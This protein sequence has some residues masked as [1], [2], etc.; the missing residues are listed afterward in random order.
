MSGK[1]TGAQVL[2]L[3]SSLTGVESQIALLDSI[4]TQLGGVSYFVLSL[5]PLLVLCR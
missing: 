1:I 3:L 2:H 4:F 5:L